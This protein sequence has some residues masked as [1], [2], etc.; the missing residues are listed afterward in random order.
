MIVSL[1]LAL[2]EYNVNKKKPHR[3]K[4]QS[5]G[6]SNRKAA[7][8]SFPLKVL[9][10]GQTT[11]KSWL[12]HITYR[13]QLT[14]FLLLAAKTVEW[15]AANICGTVVCLYGW[16]SS[17]YIW[18]FPV[19]LTTGTA[20]GEFRV[21]VIFWIFNGHDFEFPRTFPGILVTNNACDVSLNCQLSKSWLCHLLLN[22]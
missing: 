1:R 12:W 19:F 9:S 2:P 17:E 4:F 10:V 6:K 14:N 21:D 8:R 13:T 22:L 5:H 16:R 20:V 7:A 11:N 15:H 3:R 18:S